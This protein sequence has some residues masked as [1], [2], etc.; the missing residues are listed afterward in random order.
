MQI[1]AW[2]LWGGGVKYN[3]LHVSVKPMSTPN[4]E[5]EHVFISYAGNNINASCAL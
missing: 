3:R 5:Q 1:F 4:F 2:V